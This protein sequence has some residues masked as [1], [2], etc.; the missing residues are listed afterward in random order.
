MIKRLVAFILL[1]VLSFT[2]TFSQSKPITKPDELEQRF[3][4]PPTTAKPYVWWH[5]MGSNFSK[6]GIT[7]DLEAM[8]AAGI[9]GATIFN[10]T[11]AVQE[12]NAPT[13]NLPW[14]EQ[15]YRSP[16]YWEAVRFAA[17][18]AD[19]LGLEIGLHNSVGYSTT[20]GPW[21]S[22]EQGMQ[23]L[24]WSSVDVEGGKSISIN[25]PK[26]A[27]PIKEG[28]GN[29]KRQA[30]YCKDI[31]L[32][33]VPI[34]DSLQLKA[35]VNLTSLAGADG[36]IQWDAPAGNWK[37][38]RFGY[39]PTMVSPHPI[40]DELI[41]KALEVDKMSKNLNEYHWHVVIDSIKQH[42]GYYI[43][44][45]FKHLLIDSYESGNQ[46]WTATFRDEFIKRKGYDPVPWFVCLGKPITGAKDDKQLRIVNSTEETKRFEWDYTDVINRLFTDNGW[47]VGKKICNENNLALQWE[48]YS[49]PF[50][51]V[52]GA[53]LPDLPMGEFWTGGRGGINA[54]IPA[55]ARAAGKTIVGAESFT[56]QPSIS[57]FTEAP[58]SLKPSADGTYASGVNRLV[59]HHWVHQPFDDKYQPGMGMG[60]WGTHFGRHQ[61][62]AE[63]GKAFF[64]Y[65]GR[66]QA[67][68]QYGEQVADYLCVDKQ[69]GFSDLIA[70]SDF[71]VRE[72]KVENHQIILPSSR[73]YAFMVFP[74]GSVMLPAVAE[75]IKKLVTD[76]AYIVSPKPMASPSLQD[77]PMADAKVKAIGEA[78]WGNLPENNYGKGW[79]S[80]NVKSAI[81]KCNITPDCIIESADTAKDIR[82]V[83]RQDGTTNIYYVANL[84]AHPQ[85][86]TVSF[87]L[88]NAIHNNG[89]RSGPEVPEI[90]NAEDASITDAAVWGIK[91]GRTYV[92]LFL[93]G[94]Q[95]VF[96]VL[97][98]Q[99]YPPK[100]S[101]ASVSFSEQLQ[102]ERI[103]S[104]NHKTY[105]TAYR[106]ITAQVG[107]SNGKTKTLAI[108]VPAATQISG[109]WYVS[110]HPKLNKEFALI[111]PELLDFSKS[112][113]PDVKYFAGTAHYTQTINISAD[114]LAENKRIMLDLGTVNNIVQ[115]F[116]NKQD[117]GVLWYPPFKK[118]IT[119]ALKVGENT[120][121]IA[122]TNNW[123]NRLIGDEQEP[124]DFIFGTDRGDRGRALKEYPD[125][126]I[127][128]QPRPSKG[129]KAFANWYY[130]R[131]D[132][133][134]QPAGLVGP[135]L[136]QYGEA[137]GLY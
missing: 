110:F 38:Y 47:A 137:V 133:P 120:L 105:F 48:P 41:G 101:V 72:I 75:K 118:D 18:E 89:G 115:L 52:E 123:A 32:L 92:T 98:Y 3:L 90:W 23:K 13:E 50:D 19:R 66:T 99:Y 6:Y 53:G 22:P 49:G 96:V 107:F 97:R 64:A 45:S 94:V 46:N 91:N 125:W 100:P 42:L 62:W 7:K 37:I 34:T 35:I 135:V 1:M 2:I 24:V 111:F 81:E 112:D 5:W 95:S 103:T 82:Y 9:G 117:L 40:P 83:H 15:T 126:F 61:T 33:A 16:A 8:K 86:V 71:L 4:H 10:L 28:W 44:K 74:N 127:K 11:S 59:L 67:L 84:N 88:Y 114:K 119:S 56:G 14:P 55:A 57:K 58:A 31:A 17:S 116:V 39:R 106:P 29:T 65:L 21:I 87:P 113:N 130:Y 124:A 51:I 85:K 68:L 104:F 134:L 77:F 43:G 122:V 80:T 76:G 26:L 78:I 30:T 136:L 63:P 60:W 129:R 128:N 108:D 73:K 70:T 109:S 69:D 131:K 36:K 20:G 12:G 54:A 132:S 121:D 93:K 25:I 27:L 79:V 102:D